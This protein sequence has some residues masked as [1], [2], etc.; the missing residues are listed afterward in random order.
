MPHLPD[1]LDHRSAAPAEPTAPPARSARVWAWL[2]AAALPG[3]VVA[4][5]LAVAGKPV[6]ASPFQCLIAAVIALVCFLA[7][8][9]VARGALLCVLGVFSASVACWLLAQASYPVA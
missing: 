4:P 6:A 2:V 9:S 5:A 3:V 1:V 8:A 7:A